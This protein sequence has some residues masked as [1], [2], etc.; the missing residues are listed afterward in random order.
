MPPLQKLTTKAREALRRAH[1]LAI[2]RGQNHVNPVHLLCALILQEESMVASIL[3]KMEVDTPVLTDIVLEHINDTPFLDL[4][5][6]VTGI[7]ELIKADA[8][9]TLY[10]P[11]HFL[12]RHDDSHVGEGWRIAYVLSLCDGEWRL[13][14]GGYLNFLDAQGDVIAGYK[15]RFNALNLFAVPQRHQVT[16]VAPFAPVARFAITGWFRDR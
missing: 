8:Q 11:G 1:E 9:A 3:D 13:D 5:R 10:A 6:A 7:E 15:P 4:V 14:W 2:E 16:Y 12:G